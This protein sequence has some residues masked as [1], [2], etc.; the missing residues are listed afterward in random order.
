VEVMRR[1][2]ADALIRAGLRPGER[3]SVTAL[4]TPVDG[5]QVRPVGIDEPVSVSSEDPEA[6]A[7]S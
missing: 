6:G 1:G 2:R 3:V 7:S 4:E 5:M